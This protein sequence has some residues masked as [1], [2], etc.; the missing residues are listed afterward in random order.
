MTSEPMAWINKS[1]LP[2]KIFPL[3][4]IEL[5]EVQEEL[6]QIRKDVMSFLLWREGD[7]APYSNYFG[8]QSVY[9]KICYLTESE[10]R[11]LKDTHLHKA[12]NLWTLMCNS[13][14]DRVLIDIE[15]SKWVSVDW[16]ECIDSAQKSD[17]AK[18]ADAKI[19]LEQEKEKERKRRMTHI[20]QN[21][22]KNS[23]E[24]VNLPKKKFDT[25]KI[26][27]TFILVTSVLMILFVF[28]KLISGG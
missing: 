8:Y 6:E 2:S 23:L 3:L 4:N 7:F 18:L 24:S 28:F 16:K 1:D 21:N 13:S 20:D 26:V 25:D 15:T 9:S 27:F 22:M 10:V 17:V 19:N 12:N 11:R 5:G 14:E